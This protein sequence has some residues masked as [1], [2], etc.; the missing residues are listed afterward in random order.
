[1][2][3]LNIIFLLSIILFYCLL[4]K[5]ESYESK[6]KTYDVIISINVHEK[7]SFLIKQL[8]N[9]KQNVSCNYAVILNCNDYIHEE[10]KNT[11]LPENV[12][13]NPEIINKKRFHGSL[14]HGIYSN[15]N[16][17]LDHFDFK[18]FIIC[19]SRN[20]FTNNMRLED[21]NKVVELNIKPPSVGDD[22]TSGSNSLLMKYYREKNLK[23]YIM[24]IF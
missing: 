22:Y 5:N 3:Y 9:I 6:K 11:I 21:L 20:F 17:A 2:E 13:I 24:Y 7:V 16:Y 8:D 12:Y 15:M 23:I 18:Y 4:Y 1:M 10:C 14:T 19:S